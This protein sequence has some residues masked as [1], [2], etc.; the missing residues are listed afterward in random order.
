M[1]SRIF[2]REAFEF[3][4]HVT[5]QIPTRW[6][7]GRYGISDN[8]AS[9]ADRAT[10]WAFAC[11]AEALSTFDIT[12]RYEL[13]KYIHPSEVGSSSGSGMGNMTSFRRTFKDRREEKGV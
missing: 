13:Y 5:R 4:R 9:Q 3:N 12:D 11:T 10:L 7:V 8:L 2:V 6:E 1:G